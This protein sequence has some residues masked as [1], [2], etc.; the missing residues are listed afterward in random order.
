MVYNFFDKKSASP[1]D[2]SIKCSGVAILQ[3]EQLDEELQKPMIT[4]F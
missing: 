2:K 4:K 1:A 3:N